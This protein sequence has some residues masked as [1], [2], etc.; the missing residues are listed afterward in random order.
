[1]AE[2]NLQLLGA[3]AFGMMLGWNVYFVNRYRR[4][5]VGFG[6]LTTLVGAVGGA[7]VLALYKADT[8][9]FGA[10][11]LGLGIGFFLYYLNLVGL[12]AKSPN[13]TADWF[14]DGRRTNPAAGE[15]YG[16]DIAPT[17]H[18]AALNPGPA[19]NPAAAVNNIFYGTNPGESGKAPAAPAGKK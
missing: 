18:P 10:Y 6:D 16:S 17:I 9:L 11:G 3:F 15:G 4:G 12:V 19:A 5:E 7:A 14:L 2:I 13:F 8:D 1:M